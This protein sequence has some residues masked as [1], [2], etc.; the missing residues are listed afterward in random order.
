MENVS[1]RTASGISDSVPSDPGF[2][3]LF[4]IVGIVQIVTI[5]CVFVSVGRH[6]VSDRPPQISSQP[7][8]S[9]T[10]GA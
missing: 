3:F 4:T 6:T 7:S 1:R 10:T 8:Y 9:V 2:G 5:V